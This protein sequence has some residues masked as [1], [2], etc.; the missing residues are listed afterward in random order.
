MFWNAT[1]S[2]SLLNSQKSESDYWK[3]PSSEEENEMRIAPVGGGRAR[4]ASP[5]ES[6]VGVLDLVEN[7]CEEVTMMMGDRIRACPARSQNTSKS[8]LK[9]PI[10]VAGTTLE[11]SASSHTVSFLV[12][13]GACSEIA[14]D[15]RDSALDSPR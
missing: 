5:V 15:T 13:S 3:R 2:V 12:R 4:A 14:Q 10:Y 11:R 1:E 8:A 9:R 7:V 6:S